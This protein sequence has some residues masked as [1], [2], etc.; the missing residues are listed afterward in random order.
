MCV[1]CNNS[2]LFPVLFRSQQI[3]TRKLAKKHRQQPIRFTL[4]TDTCYYSRKWH[5]WMHLLTPNKH[6]L[7]DSL[8]LCFCSSQM[9]VF[10][11]LSSKSDRFSLVVSVLLQMVSHLLSIKSS[12]CRV[13]RG[14]RKM[15]KKIRSH[16]WSATSR[17]IWQLPQDSMISNHWCNTPQPQLYDSSSKWK[18][19]LFLCAGFPP[20][21]LLSPFHVNVFLSD[22][23]NFAPFLC[24][25]RLKHLSLL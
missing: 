22:L 2:I 24:N 7:N 11:C 16:S 21:Q 23:F 8:I 12:K 25:C 1:C 14:K 5:I 18:R 6:Q 20:F 4:T 19:D 17:A 10:T 3:T 15:K 9:P 13:K